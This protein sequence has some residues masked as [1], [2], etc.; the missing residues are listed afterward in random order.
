MPRSRVIELE[1][2]ISSVCKIEEKF[3]NLFGKIKSCNSISHCKRLVVL[4][5]TFLLSCAASV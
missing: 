2:C 3:S 4:G 1:A 5:V